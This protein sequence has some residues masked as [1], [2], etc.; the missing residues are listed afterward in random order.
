MNEKYIVCTNNVSDV[1]FTE[2]DGSEQISARQELMMSIPAGTREQA[3][4]GTG[5]WYI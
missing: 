4:H 5:G 2:E 3:V 1:F